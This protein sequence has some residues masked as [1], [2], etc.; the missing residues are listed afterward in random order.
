[1]CVYSRLHSPSVLLLFATLLN[2]IWGSLSIDF[3]SPGRVYDA[4]IDLYTSKWCKCSSTI[5]TAAPSLTEVCV[6]D[7]TYEN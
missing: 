3:L 6:E 7:K 5:V 1:M 2:I 4:Y